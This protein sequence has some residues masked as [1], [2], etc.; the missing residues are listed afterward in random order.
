M[1]L[2]SGLGVLGGQKGYNAPIGVGNQNKPAVATAG[3]TLASTVGSQLRTDFYWKKALIE[4]QR[5]QYFTQMAMSKA[6][7]KHMGKT[8]KKYHFIPL[9]DDRNV[10]TQGIDAL[11][12]VSTTAGSGALYA[13]SKDVGAISGKLP[14]LTE[15]GGRVNRVGFT[16]I[17][18]EATIEKFGF[19]DE[20]TQ[21]SL[22]FDTQ[23]ELFAHMQR[24]MIMGANE[25]TEDALQIDL[26]NGAGVLVYPG[27]ATS[28]ATISGEAGGE[29]VVSYEDLV[30]L[31][32]TLTDNRTPK[33]TKIITGTRM[34]DTKTIRGGWTIY[35][36]SEMRPTFERMKDFHN[37]R[38][39][40]PVNQYAAGTTLMRG[41]IG[42]VGNFRLVEV[43]EMMN[44]TGGGATVTSESAVNYR[45]NGSNYNV[46]P[47]LVVGSESFTTIGFQTAGDMVKFKITTKMPG[48]ATADRVDPY[49]ETGFSSI[50]WYYGSMILRSER[51]ALIHSVAEA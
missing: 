46:Y 23:E 25:I 15:V 5:E 48:E 10:S 30:R 45:D 1:P 13:G 36:G 29:T 34:I 4:A 7:P 11:G 43:P 17:T 39:F 2:D 47:M 19:F 32:I 18:L 35:L 9:L 6:M 16:R 44:W 33:E 27:A 14:T 38:A 37:E 3:G 26:L 50:K 21:E 24:E 31:A 28:R 51:L 42:S 41:E 20:F 49:G 22:D 8:I 12:V 40:I